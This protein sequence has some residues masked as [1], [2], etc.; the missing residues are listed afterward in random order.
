[1][2]QKLD[3]GLRTFTLIASGVGYYILIRQNFLRLWKGVGE[4]R[5]LFDDVN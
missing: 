1:M 2:K 3:A 5:G 4:L